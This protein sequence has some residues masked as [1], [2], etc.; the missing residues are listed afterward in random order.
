MVLPEPSKRSLMKTTPNPEKNA[1]DLKLL[2][3]WCLWLY[4]VAESLVEIISWTIVDCGVFDSRQLRTKCT[5][6]FAH[7]VV[8]PTMTLHFRNYIQYI[9][10]CLVRF[11]RCFWWTVTISLSHHPGGVS[12]FSLSSHLRNLPS[13]LDKPPGTTSGCW[14]RICH[15]KPTSQYPSMVVLAETG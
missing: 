11:W 3:W 12:A 13:W 2:N 8:K 15:I 10:I 14:G 7:F 1:V 9:Y 4:V 6:V 5:C